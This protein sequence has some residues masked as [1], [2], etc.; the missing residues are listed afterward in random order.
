MPGRWAIAVFPVFSECSIFVRYKIGFGQPEIPADDARGYAVI[1]VDAMQGPS[2]GSD[3]RLSVTD[4][5]PE[6]GCPYH[7]KVYKEL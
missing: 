2:Y 3:V 4:N 1:A 7:I 5:T 6:I